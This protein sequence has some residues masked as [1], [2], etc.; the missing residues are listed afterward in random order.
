MWRHTSATRLRL[1]LTVIVHISKMGK[2]VRD[3]DVERK[4]RVFNFCLQSS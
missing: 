2:G 3:D 1:E 4:A